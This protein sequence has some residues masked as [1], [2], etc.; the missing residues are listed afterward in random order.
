MIARGSVRFCRLPRYAEAVEEVFVPFDGPRATI[1][2]ATHVRSTLLCSSLSAL[3]ARKLYDTYLAL[4][5]A[6]TT[7]P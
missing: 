4:Y 7:K 2:L 3:R 6:I 5:R 1:A